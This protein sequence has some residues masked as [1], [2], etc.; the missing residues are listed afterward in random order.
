[1]ILN[2]VVRI[3][4]FEW[5]SVGVALLC[6]FI[7]GFERQLRG[8]PVGIRTASLITLG[9]WFFIATSMHLQNDVTDPSRIIG[10]VITSIGFLGA[11]GYVVSRW[12]GA[13][14]NIRSNYLGA[15]GDWCLY[16]H[17]VSGNGG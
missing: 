13:G 12:C 11:G 4:P 10:Q 1:M 9:T 8:K 7:I 16:R 3:D 14:C 2:D 15:G 6:G 17:R 5:H